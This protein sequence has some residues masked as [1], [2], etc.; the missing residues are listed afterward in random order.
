MCSLLLFLVIDVEDPRNFEEVLD[1]V[2][3]S[4][5]DLATLL[6]KH[7]NIALAHPPSTIRTGIIAAAFKFIDSLRDGE[8]PFN[9]TLL[10][11]GFISVLVKA[12]SILTTWEEG[13]MGSQM[14]LMILCESFHHPK[15][16][17]W[18]IQALQAG[19]LGVI[20]SLGPSATKAPAEEVG[21]CYGLLQELLQQALPG[22]LIYYRVACQM[23]ISFPAARALASAPDFVTS[24]IYDSWKA[25]EVFVDQRLAGLDYFESGQW[26]S[27]KACENLQASA[28]DVFAN[29]DIDS[30]LVLA[31]GQEV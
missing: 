25:F 31:H 9:T 2:G 11:H 29:I 1:G 10:S 28:P 3:G 24:A 16:D 26:I 4:V 14:V 12:L 30:N 27:S 23:K 20:I 22:S 19:L 15:S 8:G 7:I 13:A 6:L 18:I 5:C 17:R 21:N